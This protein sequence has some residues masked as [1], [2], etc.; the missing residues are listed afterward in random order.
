MGGNDPESTEI[1]SRKPERD[2]RGSVPHHIVI[3]S[4]LELP[5]FVFPQLRKALHI[6]HGLQIVRHMKAVRA[7][8]DQ[9]QQC[10]R[11]LQIHIPGS[12]VRLTHSGN[13]VLFR[14]QFDSPP[15]FQPR[16]RAVPVLFQTPLRAVRVPHHSL[17]GSV[18]VCY[19]SGATAFARIPRTFICIGR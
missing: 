12:L 17:P 13:L 6:Q 19:I 8:R 10:L 11:S 3:S 18:D 2:Q 16:F 14:T 5:A 1:R 15:L 4:R 7:Q 9:L